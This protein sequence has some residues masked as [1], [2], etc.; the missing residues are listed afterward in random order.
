M[1]PQRRFEL[2]SMIH[3]NGGWNTKLRDPA[4][5][6]GLSHR[7]CRDGVEW[8]GFRPTSEAV[9]ASEYVGMGILE[10]RAVG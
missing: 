6:E 8:D 2:L 9:Y 5:E 10:M 4:T 1:V 7:F 3:D